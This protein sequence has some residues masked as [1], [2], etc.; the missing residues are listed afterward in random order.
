MNITFYSV[1]SVHPANGDGMVV[2]EELVL[3]SLERRLNIPGFGCG[4]T[5]LVMCL[6]EGLFYA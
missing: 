1:C 4:R 3:S 2:V 6:S 5:R